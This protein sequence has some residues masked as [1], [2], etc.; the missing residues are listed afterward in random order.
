MI[1]HTIFRAVYHKGFLQ[2]SVQQ[3]DTA[4]PQYGDTLSGASLYVVL[5]KIIWHIFH[6]GYG[7]DYRNC[8][9]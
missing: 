4:E 6:G 7:N 8:T 5:P 1:G 2:N 9:F 3:Y